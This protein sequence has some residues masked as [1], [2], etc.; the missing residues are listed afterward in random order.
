[1]TLSELFLVKTPE[2]HPFSFHHIGVLFV[3]DKQL[4]S[5]FCLNDIIELTKW[6]QERLY[7]VA[8]YE[9]K[10]ELQTESLDDLIKFLLVAENEKKVV[11]WVGVY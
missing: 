10:S 6:I 1:M 2:N 7:G 8:T 5:L 11:D 9:F 4:D 3:C